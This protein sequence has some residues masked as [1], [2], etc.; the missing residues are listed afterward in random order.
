MTGTSRLTACRWKW[1]GAITWG[2]MNRVT[3][4]LDSIEEFRIE[5]AAFK[6]EDSRASG[7]NIS[8]TTKSGTNSLHGG[9]FDYYQSQK[10][11]ANSWLN[12]K[13]GRP[14]SVFH[15]NDFG[16]DVGGPVYIPK[17]YDGR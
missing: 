14:I 12:N 13:L 3:P 17:V 6:A 10:L 4:A 1:A 16:A 7:G 8:I 2:N 11:N 9:L 5:T 15:R